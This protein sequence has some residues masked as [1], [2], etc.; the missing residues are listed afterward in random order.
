MRR[1]F[2]IENTTGLRI[3]RGSLFARIIKVLHVSRRLETRR[4][5]R[6]YRHLIAEDF[7]NRPKGKLLDFNKAKEIRA[8]AN[9]DRS[10]GRAGERIFQDA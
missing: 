3:G 1:V 8:N 6:R 5:L 10:G 2:F 4:L 7:Q 9:R